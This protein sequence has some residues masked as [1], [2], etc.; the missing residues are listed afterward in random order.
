[1]FRKKGECIRGLF[2]KKNRIGNE[3]GESKFAKHKLKLVVMK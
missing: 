3:L 2:F 1:M